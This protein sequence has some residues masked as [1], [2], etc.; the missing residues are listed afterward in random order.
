ML[1]QKSNTLYTVFWK[2][3][4]Q[5]AYTVTSGVE[6]S[7]SKGRVLTVV[8]PLSSLWKSAQRTRGTPCWRTVS[9]SGVHF[10]HFLCVSR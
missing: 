6:V 2:S 10:V 4:L 5:C 8:L 9:K 3:V 7:L 1:T